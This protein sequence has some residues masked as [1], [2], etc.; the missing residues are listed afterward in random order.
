MKKLPPLLLFSAALGLSAAGC[1][2][3]VSTGVYVGVG[4]P[5]PYGGYPYPCHSCWYGRPPYYDEE[6]ALNGTAP[7]GERYAD[8]A[9][10]DETVPAP[11][12]SGDSEKG[13]SRTVCSADSPAGLDSRE[14]C[15]E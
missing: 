1:G 15:G 2:A 8:R 4:V 10:R 13:G 9:V 5:G 7:A 3:G 11:E 12:S 14:S 6:D